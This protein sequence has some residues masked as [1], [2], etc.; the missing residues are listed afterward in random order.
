MRRRGCSVLGGF[1]IG[2][3]LSLA[4]V[5]ASPAAVGPNAQDPPREVYDRAVRLYLQGSLV[6][7][8]PLFEQVAN[9]TQA[10]SAL[11]EASGAYLIRTQ[12]ILEPAQALLELERFLHRHP[13]S[14]HGLSLLRE[15]GHLAQTQGRVG[16]AITS[17]ERAG[18]YPGT[19]VEKAQLRYWM[20]EASVSL[21]DLEM[22]R[23]YFLQVADSFPE[24]DDTPNALYATGRL[25]LQEE[26][27]AQ[28]ADVFERLR[29]SHP[30]HPVT[31]R[32]GTA[33][34]ESYYQQKDYA[35]AAQAL[36]D[37]MPYLEGEAEDKAVY[38]VA[39]SYSA[40]EEYRE[41][42]RYY[43]QYIRKTQGSASER[44]AHYGLGWVYHRQKIYHWA[45][46]SF[47]EASKGDDEL[48]RKALY[49][50]AVNHKLAN[51]YDLALQS[52]RA[53]GEL[54]RQGVFW[55]EAAFEWAVTAFERGL[56]GEA[57]EVLL[58]LARRL[59]ELQRP[60]ELLSFL[61]EVYYANGEYTSA[62]QTFELAERRTSLPKSTIVR[63]RFQKA[64]VLYSNHAYAQAQPIF[65]S[66]AM[67][68]RGAEEAP[69]ALFWS[70]D[71]Y[72]QLNDFVQAS[73]QFAEFIRRHPTHM[74]VGASSYA[75]GWSHF[76]SGE[77]E[78]ALQP[79]HDFLDKYEAP[80]IALYPYETDARLRLGDAYFALG[81]YP[82]A[83]TQ[84]RKAYGAEPG[85]DYAMYQVANSYFRNDQLT[86]AI[87]EFR[88]LL[89]IYPFTFV[90]EQAQYNI[91]FIFLD[92]ENVEQA[93]VEFR[94]LIAMVPGSE[95]AARAQFAI[96]DALYNRGD[97]ATAIEAYEQVL[98]DYPRSD[99]VI[100]AIDGIQ[101]A[102]LS[103]GLPD[104]S[105]DLLESFLDNH[106]ST[107]TAD[108]L[109]Y[110]QAENLM[111]SGDYTGAVRQFQDYIRITNR[112]DLLPTAWANIADAY[113]RLGDRENARKTWTRLIEA[114][115]R[116]DE[117]STALASLGRDALET[118]D[119]QRAMEYFQ[120]LQDRGSRYAVEAWIGMG[121]AHLML[122]GI[123]EAG[124]LYDKA[125]QASASN[126]SARNGKGK[127]LIAQGQFAEA[128]GVLEP[129]TRQR[130]SESAAEA[131]VLIARTLAGEGDVEGA[132]EA[133]S[134]VAVLF[135]AFDRWIAQSWYEMAALHI[136]SGRAGDARALLDQILSTY[137][138]TPAA[139]QARALLAEVDQD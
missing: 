79:L 42:T 86:E 129:V 53:F 23:R 40:L 108:R 2:V 120:R 51:R 56:Y 70:A 34:G 102:Q 57:I 39:E 107:S 54:P 13:L 113:V 89:R 82:Q 21:G 16:D 85:G 75:L 130:F 127:V 121:D 10:S 36:L 80:P 93:I 8:M 101:Y 45:A 18:A 59:D 24:F 49:Y 110:R 31:L 58:P 32:I 29:T 96:G 20:G 61:G 52:F 26:S 138:G 106:P 131:Q 76:M 14:I 11:Q 72:F 98:K 109:R 104:R 87:S 71:S 117:A 33:L 132:L 123:T 47:E 66:I 37:A 133:Y 112:E 43:L 116:S 3:H 19:R 103:A 62:I 122:G 94:R 30:R 115:P 119:P 92:N 5:H 65:E 9:T 84:Y 12:L 90:R 88:K 60:G 134:K 15:V 83:I 6:S 111:Q 78:Q 114:L 128:R 1:L 125:L 77:Y 69:E 139:E 64:W 105:T 99:Y 136:R 28:A 97:Y 48:A 124:A 55:E 74:F 63:A 44:N 22:A 25:Y 118:G 126:A 137:N 38:L 50:T 68:D 73:R 67:K 4:P 46:K 95:W 17:F 100:E 35:K 7:A 27:F 135:E 81:R 41:A 91:G